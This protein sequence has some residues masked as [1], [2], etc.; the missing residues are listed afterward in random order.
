MV[1]KHLGILGQANLGAS[2]ALRWQ[3]LAVIPVIGIVAST[4]LTC[5]HVQESPRDAWEFAFK[6]FVIAAWYPPADT[7]AEYGIYR[8]AGFNLVMSVR[9]KL[10]DNALALAQK[11]GLKVMI[12]TYTPNDQ[13]WGGTAAPYK[14]HPTHHPAT[15]PELEWLHE[16]YGD[17]PALGGYLLGDDYGALPQELVDTTGFMRENAP[18][19]F[20]WI[21]QNVM[22]AKSLADAGNPIQDPQI[23][24]TLYQ[25]D[26]PAEKQCQKMCLD[27]QRLRTGCRRY[28]LIM[29]PMFNVC[30]VDSDSLVRF[31]VYASLAYGAQGIWYFTYRDGLQNGSGYQTV[32]QVK[33]NL[34]PTWKV[35]A[36]ANRRVAAWGPH[37]LGRTAVE[38]FNTG[39]ETSNTSRPGKGTLVETMSDDLLVGILAKPGEQPLAMVVDKRTDKLPGAIPEREVE[40]RFAGAVSGIELLGSNRTVTGSTVTL[41]LPGG[42]GQLLALEGDGL[43]K[44]CER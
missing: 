10:P 35:A 11:H 42:G 23:Y 2:Y 27:L 14:P 29:W 33:Q 44:L 8:D 34:A 26:W 39:W 43:D 40:L 4:A 36:E 18:H 15:L 17:H 1:H 41:R 24:P 7:D 6:D 12:D 5:A 38:I 16:R 30:G 31:Q 25:K 21:C 20:P 37:L 3:F 13:P 32:E 28:D 19:L 22:S 9:Y